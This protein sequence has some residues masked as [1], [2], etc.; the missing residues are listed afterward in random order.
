VCSLRSINLK[1]KNTTQG[2]YGGLGGGMHTENQTEQTKKT[3]KHIWQGNAWGKKER[4]ETGLV[5]EDVMT[6]RAWAG[7]IRAVKKAVKIKK[8][9]ILT[10]GMVFSGTKN[11]RGKNYSK[12]ERGRKKK[13]GP[14]FP[15]FKRWRLELEAANV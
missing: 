15:T 4:G 12:W 3:K 1:K 7:V 2:A 13:D 8:G 6:I 5:R 10:M 14:W 9:T 11:S